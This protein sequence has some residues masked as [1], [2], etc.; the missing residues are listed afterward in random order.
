MS[1]SSETKK[2]HT[3]G[4]DIARLR[5][6]LAEATPGE[7]SASREDMDSY[8]EDE[9]GHLVPVA[10]IYRDQEQRIPV[11][12]DQ[13][14]YDSR[15]IVALRNTA[16]ALLDEL[17]AARARHGA[18]ER[19][20][21]AAR[22][23]KDGDWAKLIDMAKAMGCMPQRCDSDPDAYKTIGEYEHDARYV[24]PDRAILTDAVL[25]QALHPFAEV[26]HAD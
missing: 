9:D 16:S 25:A 23:V 19:L 5:K 10:Y 8:T 26:G 3:E 14:R 24:Y 12:G 21:G 20:V 15:L 13:F 2:G 1:M 7:W 6:L 17:E 22:A 11:Y 18:V 4:V